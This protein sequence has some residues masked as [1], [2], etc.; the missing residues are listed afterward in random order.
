M[1]LIIG[2]CLLI[3]LISAGLIAYHESHYETVCNDF[4]IVE[5]VS[6]QHRNVKIK[7]SNNEIIDIYQPSITIMKGDIYQHCLKVKI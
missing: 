4:E 3:L 5:I 7:L 1:R 6:A 2:G